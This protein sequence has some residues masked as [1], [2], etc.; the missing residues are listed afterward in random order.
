M[1]PSDFERR[2][3]PRAEIPCKIVVDSPTKMFATHTVNIS[4]G[5]IRVTLKAR[6]DT[7]D[8]IDLELMIEGNKTICCKGKVAWVLELPDPK[9]SSQMIYD[10]GIEFRELDEPD[11]LLLRELINNIVQAKG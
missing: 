1:S 8:N 5:G 9:Q 7:R 2:R 4:E 10:T 6:L 11:R 3:F